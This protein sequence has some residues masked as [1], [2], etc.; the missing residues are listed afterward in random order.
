MPKGAVRVNSKMTNKIKLSQRLAAVAALVGKGSV[1]DIG[2]DH[3]MLPIRL[4]QDGHPGALASDINEGPCQRARTNIYEWGLHGRITVVCAPGLAAVREYKPDNIVIAGMGG[5]MIASIIEA[6]DY[7]MESRCRLVL[8]PQSMQD[9]LR[10]FLAHSGFIITDETVVEDAGKYYQV[11]AAVYDGIKRTFTDSEYKLGA[12][13][14]KRCAESP[15]DTDRKWLK[16]QRA[17]AVRRIEGRSQGNS[18]HNDISEQ[19][20]D[21]E[22]L[23]LIDKLLLK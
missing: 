15:A 10:R 7:P 12:L 13:N 1:A 21:R 22:L 16:L 2:T 9:V 11:I 3:A 18:E 6:S 20:R 19:S 5:E 23:A 8:Q 4:V 14:I 17:S